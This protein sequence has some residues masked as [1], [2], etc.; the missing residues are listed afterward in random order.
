MKQKET[1]G[2]KRKQYGTTRSLGLNR[3]TLVKHKKYGYSY[4]GG[5]SKGR[6]SLHDIVTNKRFSRNIKV[7]DCEI[8]HNMRWKYCYITSG[9]SVSNFW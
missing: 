7:S 8:K 9:K 1:K 2:N 5:S 4:V 3:G 6:I